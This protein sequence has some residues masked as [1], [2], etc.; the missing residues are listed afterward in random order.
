V[1]GPPL[2]MTTTASGA[3]LVGGPKSVLQSDRVARQDEQSG[4]RLVGF[5][6][7][8]PSAAENP[9]GRFAPDLRDGEGE[10][11]LDRSL[12]GDRVRTILLD[13]DHH[14][15]A[16]SRDSHVFAHYQNGIGPNVV[17]IPSPFG[18]NHDYLARQGPSACGGTNRNSQVSSK[19]CGF[20]ALITA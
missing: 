7:L 9:Y 1:S 20:L 6:G 10:L 2:A 13:D 17:V 3:R 18:A 8:K 11:T 19:S 4:G 14:S 12:P 16:P 5:L 15:L